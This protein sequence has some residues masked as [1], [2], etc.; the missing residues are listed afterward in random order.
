[1]NFVSS[2]KF[3]GSYWLS[4]NAVRSPLYSSDKACKRERERERER[5]SRYDYKSTKYYQAFFLWKENKIS[6][7]NIKLLLVQYL[8]FYYIFWKL[9]QPAKFPQC[10]IT[11]VLVSYKLISYLKEN[12]KLWTPY[13]KK[14]KAPL[15]FLLRMHITPVA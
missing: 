2:E 3:S 15:F 5:G 9:L 13:R 11:P 7:V 10:L 6:L 14:K 4:H 12:I 1:M 8:Y